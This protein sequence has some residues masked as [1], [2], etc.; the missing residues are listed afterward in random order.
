MINTWRQVGWGVVLV[1]LWGLPATAIETRYRYHDTT[2]E[3]SARTDGL[4]LLSDV[5]AA[6]A[7]MPSSFPL[8]FSRA[9]TED[10]RTWVPT[11]RPLDGNEITRLGRQLWRRCGVLSAPVLV[12]ES[13]NAGVPK[14][15]LLIVLE[16]GVTEWR[17]IE[18]LSVIR[19]FPGHTPTLLARFV[20]APMDVFDWCRRLETDPDVRSV[21]P[22]WICPVGPASRPNDPLYAEQWGL[23]NTGQGPGVA[24]A[25]ARALYGL[26]ARIDASGIVIA[27]IDEGV[28]LLHPDLAP[29]ILPGY[30]ATDLAPPSGAPGQ[31]ASNDE[32]G[33]AC[34][35]I[36]AAVGDNG[37]GVAG[38]AW[39]AKILPVRVGYGLHWT[40]TAWTID[41]ITWAAD[42]GAHIIS[43][44]WGGSLPDTAQEAA[45]DYARTVGRSGAGC[46]VIFAAQNNNGPVA[47]PAAYANTIAVGASSPCDERCAPFSCDGEWWWGSNFGPAL[48]LVAP[49]VLS[50]TT[51]LLGSAGSDLGDYEPSFGGTSCAT[52]FVAGAVALL[53]SLDPSLT[54]GDV[55]TRLASTCDDQVGTSFED[56]PGHDSYMGW[57]RLNLRHLLETAR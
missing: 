52:P 14:N 46:V 17:P 47:Y 12:D 35:G 8:D 10:G 16:D 15:E 4:W 42:N 5:G 44:S 51:D 7:E 49:G 53:L 3:L 40:E 33:T 41:A 24:G 34:A 36:A 57:G 55:E 30:D 9:V 20:G 56:T 2:I 28:E 13:G 29:N 45:I 50:P 27:I 1:V 11:T 21:S 48:T 38:V 6:E 23:E 54:V 26:N 25:D 39:S 19:V 43:C 22:N 18:G 32:H 37:I 31:A